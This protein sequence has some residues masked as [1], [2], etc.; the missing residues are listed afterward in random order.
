VKQSGLLI[1][2][3]AM[4]GAVVLPQDGIAD[5]NCTCRA[6]G[7]KFQIGEIVCIRGR[8]AQCQMNQNSPSW[9]PIGDTCPQSRM[10]SRSSL[11]ALWCTSSAGQSS[12]F[13]YN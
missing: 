9:Q 8:L 7:R 12:S 10:K 2:A 4:T 3:L 6:S 5:P 13:S 1:I 11:L